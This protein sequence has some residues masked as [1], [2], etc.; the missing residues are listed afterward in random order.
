MAVPVEPTGPGIAVGQ[1]DIRHRIPFDPQPGPQFL[2]VH[3][4]IEDIFYGGARGGGKTYGML[5]D[6]IDHATI[7]K[8]H[9]IGVF[10]R[11]IFKNLEET[12]AE[13]KLMF[14]HFNGRWQEK[15]QSFVF[16]KGP[17][18]GARL[19]MRHLLRDEDAD[20]YQGHAYTWV[21]FEEV[22]QWASSGPI[23]K[24]MA[25]L[26]SAYGVPCVFRATGNPGGAG[27]NWVKHRY[28]IGEY[29]KGF[30]IIRDPE[31]GLRRTFI[32][33]KLEDNQILMRQDPLYE[34]RLRKVGTDAL[35]KAWRY[36]NW[37]I[38]AGGY[39]DD[40]WDSDRIMLPP[41]EIPPSWPRRR[42]FDWGS[43]K[44]GSLGLW[45]ISDGV[46]PR[47]RDGRNL[48]YFP[49]GTFVRFGEW[50]IAKR[51]DAGVAIPNVGLRMDNVAMGAAIAERTRHMQWSGDV[52]DPSIFVAAGGE[53][54]FDQLQR[55]AKS[56]G[57]VLNWS[58]ADNTRVAGWQRMRS[59]IQATVTEDWENPGLYAFETCTDF[60]RTIPV[61]QADKTRLDDVDSDG[62]DHIGDETRYVL[63]SSGASA[64]SPSFGTVAVQGR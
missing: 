62:E 38:V 1:F 17:C 42:S 43:S 52:A 63:N 54:V 23:D 56:R 49:H 34:H 61:L 50:Y 28:R 41:F 58:G 26:R 31:T 25:T 2:L 32:P 11:K 36:G 45:A 51:D 8:N 7:H 33:A 10:F 13:A 22:T 46:Q 29:P 39:F 6:W 30:E 44:P 59:M 55:G 16:G 14:R 5:L 20:A 4:P 37:N 18:E 53:S 35:I 57:H 48:P 24:L 27:H 15:E 3:S 12:I 19:K 60:A 64:G 21:C 47:S 40:I 9:A